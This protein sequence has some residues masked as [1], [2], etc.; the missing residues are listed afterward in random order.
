MHSRVFDIENLDGSNKVSRWK[1]LLNKEYYSLDLKAVSEDFSLGRLSIVDTPRLRFG[2]VLCDPIDVVRRRKHLSNNDNDFYFIPIPI[3]QKLHLAQRG[4]DVELSPGDFTIISTNEPYTYL[5]RTKNA[6][7]TLRIDGGM[8]RA[9]IPFLDDIVAIKFC[10]KNALVSVFF[11]FVQSII[12]QKDM[13]DP[14]SAERLVPH[15]LDLLALAVSTEKIDHKQ[16]ET[17]V[18]LAHLRRIFQAIDEDIDNEKLGISTI[19]TKLG[20]SK[21][22]IQKILAYRESTVSS[23]IRSRRIDMAKRWLSD[24]SRSSLSIATIGFSVGFSDAAHFSRSFRDVV[25]VSPKYYRKETL[26]IKE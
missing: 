15:L 24:S 2:S 11:K 21:R 1:D 12:S 4:R 23:A 26:G 5:Q 9:R 13:L 8:A 22:Y 7:L 19:S 10:A 3:F 25:G 6:H 17:L 16:S 18:R 14:V 20:L